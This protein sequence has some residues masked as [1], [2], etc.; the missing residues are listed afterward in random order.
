MAG[1]SGAPIFSNEPAT[2]EK[3]LVITPA[4]ALEMNARVRDI[5]SPDDVP[6]NPESAIVTHGE[7]V[8]DRW[9]FHTL[10][11]PRTLALQIIRALRDLQSMNE[12]SILVSEEECW[13]LERRFRHNDREPAA[14]ALLKKIHTLLLEFHPELMPL[15]LPE[16][17]VEADADK[18]YEDAIKGT[19]PDSNTGADEEPGEGAGTVPAE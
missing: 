10:E 12:T 16:E 8:G 9:N 4:E 13:F 1:G 6:A 3:P 17:E 2:V 11:N 19:D 7:L 18:S 15:Q 14:R 5:L